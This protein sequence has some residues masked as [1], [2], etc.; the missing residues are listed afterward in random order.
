MEGLVTRLFISSTSSLCDFRYRVWKCAYTIFHSSF[1]YSFSV[2]G[3]EISSVYTTTK[4]DVNTLVISR[5]PVLV[6]VF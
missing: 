1:D 5:C 6:D 3:G 2:G 4:V